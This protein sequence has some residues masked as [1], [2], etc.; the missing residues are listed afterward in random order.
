MR[1]EIKWDQLRPRNEINHCEVSYSVYKILH[2]FSWSITNICMCFTSRWYALAVRKVFTLFSQVK[3]AVVNGKNV[4]GHFYRSWVFRWLNFEVSLSVRV[5]ILFRKIPVLRLRLSCSP[6]ICRALLVC[7]L[8]LSLSTLLLRRHKQYRWFQKA[9]GIFLPNILIETTHLDSQFIWHNP[10]C[11]KG[12][13]NQHLQALF[14]GCSF[15][16]Y[17]L[18]KVGRRMSHH[19]F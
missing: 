6:S 5:A 14:A 4:L 10:T 11:R 13:W 15:M 17:Y 7:S 1:I 18:C 3:V 16:H 8:P 12:G 2:V 19:I 9:T